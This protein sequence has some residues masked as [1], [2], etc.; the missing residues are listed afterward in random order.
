MLNA[1]RK[2][3]GTW[4]VKGFL[5]ILV[6]SFAVW[7]IGDI[8]R[9]KP[10]SAVVSVGDIAVSGTEFIDEFNKDVRRL[11]RQFGSSFDSSQ[12]RALGFVERTVQRLTQRMLYDQEVARLGLTVTDAEILHEIRGSA[13]FQ[14]DLGSFD[15][16]LFERTLAQNGYS[17]LSY[18][19]ATRR[20]GSRTQLLNA[21]T[22]GV[23]GP[24][25]VVDAIYRYR[26][27]KRVFEILTLR[28]DAMTGLA[29]PDDAALADFHQKNQSNFMA[30]EYRSLT[31][32][33]LRPE[34]LTSEIHISDEDIAEAY[35]NR[36]AEFTKTEIRTVEQI[37]VQKKERADAISARLGEGGAFYAIAK[38]MADLDEDA[39]KLGELTRADLTEEVADAV[40]GLK[41][42]AIGPPV[43][44]ALGWH[45][46]RVRKIVP[47]GVTPLADVREK[48]STGLKL[49]RAQDAIFNLANKIEDELASG[50]GVEETAQALSLTHGRLNQIDLN[51]RNRAGEPMAKLPK[52]P[53]FLRTAFDGNI[54]GDLELKESGDGSYYLVRVDRIVEPKIRPLDTV[55]EAVKGALLDERRGQAAKEKIA[56]LAERL[57]GGAELRVLAAGAKATVTT[58]PAVVLTQAPKETGINAK[59]AS[60]LFK[61]PVGGSANGA[62]TD[63]EAYLLARVSKIEAAD[64]AREKESV[65][66]L[67]DAI[68]QSISSDLVQQFEQALRAEYK[69]EVQR[70][71]IDALFNNTDNQRSF[72]N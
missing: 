50:S 57:K 41:L 69:V 51:G 36:K 16:F 20:D 23:V 49:E 32:L 3:S 4:L 28:R 35:E 62:S 12:A 22:G 2:S 70:N 5:G 47:G 45:V 48:I 39:V 64:P 27:E 44:S 46:F 42:D 29:E 60:E 21:V 9:L 1:L 66:K 71:I 31:Y 56:A 58:S 38:A 59:M 10:D 13:V 6:L 11:Q 68:A 40:F 67:G 34:Q 25:A 33:T 24:S 55:R 61:A 63:G 72:A 54:G 17:E 37:V 15:R 14:N 52:A 26:Q 7:G 19:A 53:E 43:Q 30:P 18:I 65:R 8:F